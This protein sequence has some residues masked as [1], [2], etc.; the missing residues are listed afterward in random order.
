MSGKIIKLIMLSVGA[1]VVGATLSMVVLYRGAPKDYRNVDVVVRAVAEHYIVP[2]D[3]Q[4][5]LMTVTDRQTITDSFLQAAENGDKILIYKKH[6]L[7]I[8][9]RP[10]ANKIVDVGT[11]TLDAVRQ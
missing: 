3:E 11:V 4:P 5:A 7:V 10:V 2:A 9:Y 6:Q 1:V 8:I